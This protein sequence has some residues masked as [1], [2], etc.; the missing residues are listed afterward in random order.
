MTDVLEEVK[1]AQVTYAVRD[2]NVDDKAISPGDIL[3]ILEGKIAFVDSDCEASVC[4]LLDEMVDDD[5]SVI[6][7]FYGEDVTPENAL[8]IKDKLEARYDECDVYM[9]FGGQPVYY[10][11][12]SVE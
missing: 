12:I 4:N 3:G 2:T 7:L 6:T 1:S 8:A 9:H 5:S 10:Y 11:F